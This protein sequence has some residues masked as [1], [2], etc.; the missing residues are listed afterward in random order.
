MQTQRTG[1]ADRQRTT[2]IQVYSGS[3]SVMVTVRRTRWGVLF[4]FKHAAETSVWLSTQ[5]SQPK[6]A[7]APL[8]RALR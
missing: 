5:L 1:C 4:V 8:A 6:G 2:T 7:H 3:A